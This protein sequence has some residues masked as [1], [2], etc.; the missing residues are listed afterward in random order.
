MRAS[1]EWLRAFV[2]HTLS[3]TQLAQLLSTHVATVDSIEP[4]RADLAPI[5]VGRV[6]TAER[7][8]DSD[9]L[10]VTTVDDGS[11]VPL[12]V[13]CGASNVS[14]GT[15]YPFARSGTTMPN[16]MKIEKRKIRGAVSNG[17]LCSAKELGLGDDHSGI[18]ALDV[19]VAPGTPFLQAMPI[20]DS[21]LEIDVLP[22]RPDLLCHVGIAREVSALTG[23]KMRTPA[24]LAALKPL[25]KAVTAATKGKAGGVSVQ[26]D[27]LAACPRYVAIVIRGVKVG[28][29]PDWLRTRVECMGGR[30]ISNVVDVT[31]YFLHA[32]GQPMHAF[33]LAKLARSTIVVRRARSGEKLTTLDG[34]ARTLTP[35]MLVI[36]D[37][38]RAQ[39]VA[40]VI[41]GRDSE[42]T[43]ATT[44][45]VLEVANF[46]A[47]SI[48]TTRRALGIT[49]DASHRFERGT[50]P[51]E[52]AHAGALAAALIA[53]VAG[54]SVDGAPL[55]VGAAPRSR[56]S[57]TVSPTRVSR[58]LGAKVAPSEV[59][60]RLQ[61]IG[62]VVRPGGK[63]GALKVTPPSWRHDVSRDVDLVEEIARLRGYDTLSDDLS[64]FK[65][66]AAPDHPLQVVARRVRSLMV[67]SGFAE[68][69]PLPF[70]RGDDATHIRV[71]NPLAD[72]EPHLRT[73]L[74]DTLA[75]RAEYNLSRREGNIRLFEIGSAFVPLP[76]GVREELHVAA[77]MM[78]A[79]TPPHF[80]AAEPPAFDAWDAK[81]LGTE[82][83]STVLPGANLAVGA[84]GESVLWRIVSADRDVGEVRAI[85]L[86]A[87]PWAS[88]AFGI[89]VSLGVLPVAAVAPPQQ[90][91][92]AGADG[93]LRVAPVRYRALPVMPPAEF[94]LAFVSPGGV[95]AAQIES[96]IRGAAGELLER[97]TLFDEFRGAGVP[98]GHRSLAWRL[99]FRHPERTLND[100]EIAGRR[101]KILATVEKELPGVVARAG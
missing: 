95:A 23:V 20:G 9:H 65:P 75:R 56:A 26:I 14:A 43:E 47:R 52:P 58:L 44:D 87:P 69:R 2:P 28:P 99:T 11:G 1:H 79:R 39:G 16:G 70:V 25:K 91:A 34:V 10:W 89:E 101:Q 8:P 6:I 83:V 88:P 22:N 97:L 37:A 48:R 51:D 13:V 17:M 18:L 49:T 45:I 50:D 98:E 74:L 42:V 33:D 15:L 82:I 94:D 84:Q 77:L 63:T 93:D 71:T 80:S 66:S 40:G 73:S 62:F 55:Y 54:G 72:D 21:A 7:H 46:D 36:A 35:E 57:V 53:S 30:S 41:G 81:A 90:H 60:S 12:E 27:D 86:D 3:A 31:N 29:S 19:N 92:Y 78:G 38:D 67:A 100:K 85:K 64:P 76:G 4:L 5:V 68:V 59:R 61:S 96:V 32:Y 24:E